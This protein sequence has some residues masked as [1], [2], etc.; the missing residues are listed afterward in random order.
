MT[1]ENRKSSRKARLTPNRIWALVFIVWSLFLSGAFAAV[2]GAPGI[3]QAWRL[4]RLLDQR[5][6][7]SAGLERHVQRL[8]VEQLRLERS[9]SVQ[10]REIRRVLGYAAHDELVFDFSDANH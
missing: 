8:H 7:T 4:G 9:P 6:A 1:L 10:R 5:L 2:T 3:L